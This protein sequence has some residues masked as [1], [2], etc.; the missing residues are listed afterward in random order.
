MVCDEAQKRNLDY[1]LNKIVSFIVSP[2]NRNFDEKQSI[3]YFVGKVTKFDK[4]GVWYEHPKT[5]NLN[6]IFYNYLVCIAE[7]QVI[8]TS[9]NDLDQ[10][11]S[12]MKDLLDL[13]EKSKT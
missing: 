4:M 10:S 7:E 8:N 5:K 13:I 11:P 9:K 2:I 1:F 6:F 3:E 12:N